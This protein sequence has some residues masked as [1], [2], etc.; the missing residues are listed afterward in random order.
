M[1]ELLVSDKNIKNKIYEIRGKQVMLDSD[2]AEFYE[3]KNGTK[4]VNLAVKRHA[5]RFPNDFYFQLSEKEFEQICGFNLK[6]QK[7]KIRNFYRARSSNVS[8]SNSY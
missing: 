7:N 8:I 1:E 5:N 2:L 3:C 6:P 4:S